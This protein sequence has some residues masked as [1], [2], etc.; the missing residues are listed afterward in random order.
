MRC[1]QS[2]MAVDTK[3][4]P[5]SIHMQLIPSFCRGRTTC[6]ELQT[7]KGRSLHLISH[8][9]DPRFPLS[10]PNQVAH[11]RLIC[12][13]GFK[14]DQGGMVKR[15]ALGEFTNCTGVETANAKASFSSRSKQ[16]IP[17]PRQTK[18]S[19]NRV[20]FDRMRCKVS[21]RMVMPPNHY[22]ELPRPNKRSKF[23]IH[24]CSL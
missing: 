10:A 11:T 4:A 16:S 7:S 14:Q 13:F 2:P 18:S 1:F 20:T 23:L 9:A 3:K 24:R 17:P 8:S 5:I 6:F 19:L 12:F 15:S 21:S 22:G